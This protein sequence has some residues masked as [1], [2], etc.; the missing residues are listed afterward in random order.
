[1]IVALLL[2][3]VAVVTLLF[4]FFFSVVNDRQLRVIIFNAFLAFLRCFGLIA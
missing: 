2:L 3:L 1:M 4:S